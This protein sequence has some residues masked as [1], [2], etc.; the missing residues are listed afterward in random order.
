M[1]VA[2]L[3]ASTADTH[4]FRF[5][6]QGVDGTTA[7]QTHTGTQA[8]HLLVNDL[9]QAAFVGYT[10]FDTFRYQFVSCVIALE[11]AVGGAFGHRAQGAHTAIGFV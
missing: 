9:F 7:G 3:D 2:F 8:A 11:V 4:E 6:T 10:A 1:N 5:G